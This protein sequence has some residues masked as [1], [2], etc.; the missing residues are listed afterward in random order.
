[1]EVSDRIRLAGREGVRRLTRGQNASN[2]G[3]IRD[4]SLE[5]VSCPR[6]LPR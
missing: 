1:M 2:A 4:V 3:E 6:H 5:L